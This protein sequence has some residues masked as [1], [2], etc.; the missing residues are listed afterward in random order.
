MDCWGKSPWWRLGNYYFKIRVKYAY[1]FATKKDL[2]SLLGK[3]DSYY[4]RFRVHSEDLF[5]WFGK[6]FTTDYY[7]K[8]IKVWDFEVRNSFEIE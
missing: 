4:L 1:R 3:N 5:S 6:V 2:K 8:T 7:K